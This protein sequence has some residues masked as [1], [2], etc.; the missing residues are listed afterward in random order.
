MI[1]AV[2]QNLTWFLK[3]LKN[4]RKYSDDTVSAYQRDIQAFIVFLNQTNQE[5][6]S[7]LK[8]DAYDVEAYLTSLYDHNYSKNSVAQKVSALRTFY[9]YLIKN[10][11]S[12]ANPFEYVHLKAENKKLPRFFYQSEMQAL[13]NSVA[14]DEDNPLSTRNLALLE[15]FYA[16]GIRVSECA[17]LTLDRI[18]FANKMM[19]IFGKGNKQRYVPFGEHAKD[20]LTK[21]LPVRERLMVNHH[22]DH[23][24]LFINHYGKPISARGIEYVLDD[25]IKKSSL[26]SDIHPHMLRHTFAT[27]MLNNGADMRTVQEL[28]GHASLSSTQIYTH[29]TKSHLVHDYNQFFPRSNKNQE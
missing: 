4:E 22:E 11:L 26:S 9:N 25:I 27:A 23:Q 16:T 13:F 8:V 12:S 20:A 15:V 21:Y 14:E 18:D 24:Y 2:D 29:V 1:S 28:L 10:D 6:A 17:G 5:D 7:L 19:L 3:Y